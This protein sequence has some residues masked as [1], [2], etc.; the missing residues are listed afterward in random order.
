MNPK[1]K[2]IWVKA[3]QSGEYKQTV[4]ILCKEVQGERKYCCLG[5]LTDLF[6]K[7]FPGKLEETKL[8]NGNIQYSDG[9]GFHSAFLPAVVVEWAELELQSPIVMYQNTRMVELSSLNDNNHSFTE[10]AMII[11][12]SETL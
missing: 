8:R 9:A 6:T 11:K 1:V 2:N 12:H 10:I 7:E 4:G 3:L 5:V